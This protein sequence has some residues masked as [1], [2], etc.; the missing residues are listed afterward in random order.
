ML[1]ICNGMIRSGS[2]LLFNI[3]QSIVVSH[4]VGTAHGWKG[5]TEDSGLVEQLLEWDNSSDWHVIKTHRAPIG[6][7]DAS[8]FSDVYYL[9]SYRDLRDV[10]ISANRQFCWEGDRLL[11]GVRNAVQT[12]HQMQ[13]IPNTLTFCYEDLLSDI[14]FVVRSVAAHL[15][16]AIDEHYVLCCAEEWSREAVMKRQERLPARLRIRR[17]AKLSL[18]RLGLLDF[19]RP[20]IEQIPARVK[21]R[22]HQST[23][24]IHPEHISS[25]QSLL[26]PNISRELQIISSIYS[27]WLSKH[28]YR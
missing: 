22:P 9:Y 16:V 8:Q 23:T 28:D 5:D 20:L 13:D 3:A 26:K 17:S 6:L 27:D 1:L 2:T 12:W 24:L 7:L 15:D 19:A 21:G 4:G 14:P 10:A 11:A 25:D 18:A